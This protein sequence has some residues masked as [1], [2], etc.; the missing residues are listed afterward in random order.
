MKTMSSQPK[1]KVVMQ[2]DPAESAI[3]SFEGFEA[4]ALKSFVPLACSVYVEFC[5]V[6]E[7]QL[8]EFPLI[9]FL[10]VGAHRSRQGALR[11]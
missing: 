8:I 7:F 5:S 11:D 1:T 2:G 4:E 9:L 6:A 10:P 3:L